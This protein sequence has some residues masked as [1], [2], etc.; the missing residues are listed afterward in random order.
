MWPSIVTSPSPSFESVVFEQTVEQSIKKSEQDSGGLVSNEDKIT[1]NFKNIL[2]G[3]EEEIEK[4]SGISSDKKIFPKSLSKFLSILMSA[5]FNA[6][7]KKKKIVKLS[8]KTTI[9]AWPE[10]N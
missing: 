7:A 10:Q 6:L 4:N 2:K 3:I 8:V 5:K 1:D 9:K